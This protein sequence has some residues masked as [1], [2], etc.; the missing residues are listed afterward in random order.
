[1][2]FVPLGLVR[3]MNYYQLPLLLQSYCPSVSAIVH[4]VEIICFLK[5][6]TLRN[7]GAAFGKNG[8]I[9]DLP[10]PEPKSVQP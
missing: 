9:S 7:A 6:L 8:Q 3:M 1:M 2:L 5:F 10:E 4:S